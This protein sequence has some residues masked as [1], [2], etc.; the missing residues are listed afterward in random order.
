VRSSDIY[1]K[2]LAQSLKGEGRC[3]EYGSGEYGCGSVFLNL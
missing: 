2:L 1:V 3:G